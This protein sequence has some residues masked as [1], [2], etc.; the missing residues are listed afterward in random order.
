MQDM[1]SEIGCIPKTNWLYRTHVKYSLKLLYCENTHVKLML[2]VYQCD[3]MNNKCFQIIQLF[4]FH[5]DVEI[6]YLN[7]KTQNMLD[8]QTCIEQMQ[9]NQNLVTVLT[10]IRIAYVYW[11]IV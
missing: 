3:D 4:V 8:S 1:T 7:W 5:I 9:C 11:R 6:E 10:E 2:A